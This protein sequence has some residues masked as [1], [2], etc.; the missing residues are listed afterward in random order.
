MEQQRTLGAEFASALAAKD[1][2]RLG[3]LLHPEIEFRALTPRHQWQA[4][5]PEATIAILFGQWFE[6]SDEIRSLEHLED[7]GLP[8]RRRIGY[9]LDVSNREGH[10]LVAQQAFLSERDGRIDRLRVLCSG[11]LPVPAP[12]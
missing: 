7:E 10:F 1:A 8:D 6:E 9:R 12:A 11:Y 5:D 2:V 3:E 4:D